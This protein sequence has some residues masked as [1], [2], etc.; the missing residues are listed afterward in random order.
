M[1]LKLQ[2]NMTQSARDLEICEDYWAFDNTADYIAHVEALCRKHGITTQQL[3]KE[4]SQCFA[5]L[6]DVLCN[7]CGYICTVEVPADIPYMRSIE[8]W[9]CEVCEYA[10]WQEYQQNK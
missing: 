9:C 10:T 5:Y 1:S 6:D 7:H 8:G 2:P 3:F 4:I